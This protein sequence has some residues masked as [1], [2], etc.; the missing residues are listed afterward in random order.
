MKKILNWYL[1][2]LLFHQ[3]FNA[4]QKT[5]PTVTLELLLQKF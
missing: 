4:E 2:T 1:F 3:F 5:P